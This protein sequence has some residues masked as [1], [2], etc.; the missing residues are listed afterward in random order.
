M[1]ALFSA[2]GADA[3]AEVMVPR[4]ALPDAS[5]SF[6][7]QPVVQALPSTI[8][9]ESQVGDQYPAQF[10]ESRQ[11]P[12]LGALV[13]AQPDESELTPEMQC[14]AGAIYFEA[15][16]ETLEGQLAVGQVIV[17]RTASGR[18]P[19]SYCGVVY[20]PSQFSFVRGKSMPRVRAGSRAWREAVAVARIA[21][22]GSWDSEVS[23]AL[24][25]HA[26]RVSP[27][28]RLTRLARVDNHVFY[29]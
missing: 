19:E 26:A 16:G 23:D 28:W 2:Q 3:A 1:T 20:Q 22:E 27:R 11:A 15:R 17:N 6:I 9:S 21:H 24:Y 14:L 4:L 8:E 10:A 5:T 25:F 13:A 29:R 18:F 7:S 12:T